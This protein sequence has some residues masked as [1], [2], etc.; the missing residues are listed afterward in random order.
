[1][2]LRSTSRDPYS[3]ATLLFRRPPPAAPST[4]AADQHRKHLFLTVS[5]ARV[6]MAASLEQK[7]HGDAMVASSEQRPGGAAATMLEISSRGRAATGQ[8]SGR[9]KQRR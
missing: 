1:M 5:A 8:S 7:A 3:L 6:A 2:R 9:A 4:T